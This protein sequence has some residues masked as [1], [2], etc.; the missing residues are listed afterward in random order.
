MTWALPPDSRAITHW[1]NDPFSAPLL[2]TSGALWA[3]AVAADGAAV[4]ATGAGAGP[5]CEGGSGIWVGLTGIRS[6]WPGS[7]TSAKWILLRL[8]Q[9]STGHA[10]WLWE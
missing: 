3:Y 2:L 5:R 4:A 9:Y 6:T 7:M 1:P 8:A 10:F